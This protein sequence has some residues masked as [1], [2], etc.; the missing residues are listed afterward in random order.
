M[1]CAFSVTLYDPWNRN[2]EI[3]GSCAWDS[4]LVTWKLDQHN[5]MLAHVGWDTGG[6]I[7]WQGFQYFAKLN[8]LHL[9][10]FDD[11]TQQVYNIGD[12][13][14]GVR[15]TKWT[16]TSKEDQQV[17]KQQKTMK[18]ARQMG[19]PGQHYRHWCKAALDCLFQNHKNVHDLSSACLG[20]CL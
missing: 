15:G 14:T 19:L 6:G 5:R 10:I 20:I 18:A 8:E 13:S 3:P 4:N 7:G 11:N 16:P 1:G 9:K 17:N 2:L 12:S